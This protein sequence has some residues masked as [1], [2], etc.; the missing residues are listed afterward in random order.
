MHGT[1]DVV[2]PFWHGKKLYDAAPGEKMHLWI[3][4]GRHNDYAY[5]AG[6]DYLNAFQSF[7]GRVAAYHSTSAE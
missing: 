4:G 7:I 6:D 2:I 5:V 1:E 3:D